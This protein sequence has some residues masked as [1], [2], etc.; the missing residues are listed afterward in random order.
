[1]DSISNYTAG[2]KSTTGRT[3]HFDD[4]IAKSGLLFEPTPFGG[5]SARPTSATP[6]QASMRSNTS[7]EVVS[8]GFKE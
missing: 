6:S 2:V 8:Y 3:S 4:A 7:T 5:K 1:M